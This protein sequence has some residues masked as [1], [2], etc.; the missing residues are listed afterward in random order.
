MP[1]REA[2]E[3]SR[4]E[5]LQQIE[6]HRDD[7][8]VC[9]LFAKCS[10]D[11]GRTLSDEDPKESALMLADAEAWFAKALARKPDVFD[12]WVE[13]ARAAY[14][15]NRFDEEATFGRRAL[16]SVLGAPDASGGIVPRA[17]D[18]SSVLADGRA[19][20]ALR[21]IGDAD[22]R[23]MSDRSG[24]DPVVELGGLVEGA[25]ALGLVAASAFADGN[26]WLSFASFHGG[27]GLRR[28]KLAILEEGAARLP[29][30]PELYAEINAVLWSAGRIDLAPSE[31]DRIASLHPTSA[32]ASWFAGRAWIL[33]AEDLRRRE[34]PDAAIAAYTQ[35]ELRL[36]RALT[37]RPDYAE[38]S[39]WWIGA[40]WLGRGFAQLLADRRADAAD[41]LAKAVEVTPAIV[42][43]KDGLDREVVDLVDGCLEWRASGPSPVDPLALLDRLEAAEPSSPFWAIAISDAEL[44]EA[45]RSDGR[46][47]NRVERETVDASGKKI[48]MPM[49]LPT[50]EGDVQLRASIA[51][52]RHAV[53][54]GDT[55]EN[56]QPLAQS[57]TIWGERMLD[58]DRPAD[59]RDALLEAARLMDV[60]ASNAATDEAALRD[61]A[62]RLRAVLGDARPRYRP[63]R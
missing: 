3:A 20:E 61:L 13:R 29:A 49:G 41:D 17:S 43:A 44:R 5:L 59:A 21:W 23:L 1:E 37:V 28:E 60:D 38:N 51:A 40:S 9:A 11:L 55:P 10:L 46:N 63:G 52:A 33:A 6:N 27:L 34:Q 30:A 12:W 47:P 4:S 31:T 45:L 53:K 48:R 54:L 56:R 58:R 35:A 2:L 7:P 22:A 19:I 36:E 39:K 42:I 14:F 57:L 18:A 62:V 15:R 8:E 16:A 24:K 32:D 25:R 50:E 26:D